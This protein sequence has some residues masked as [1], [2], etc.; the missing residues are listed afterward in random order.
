LSTATRHSHARLYKMTA[1]GFRLWRK[2]I[3]PT[4]KITVLIGLTFLVAI[5]SYQLFYKQA[6]PVH[7]TDI[8]QY[9]MRQLNQITTNLNSKLCDYEN[10]SQ[11]FFTNQ[12][13]NH[14]L[15][16]YIQ[17]NDNYDVATQNMAFANF[18]NGYA[19]TD[20]Y[21]YDAMFLDEANPKRKILTMGES[22][23][24]PFV[25]SFH[26]TKWFQQIVQADG[27][28]MWFPGA[29]LDNTA[30]YYLFLGR[31]VKNLFSNQPLGVLLLVIREKNICAMINDNR[32]GDEPQWEND[33]KSDFTVMTDKRGK[34]MVTPFKKDIG[35]SIRRFLG[36]HRTVPTAIPG[37]PLS[38]SYMSRLKKRPV[39]VVVHP[40]EKTGWHLVNVIPVTPQVNPTLFSKCLRLLGYGIL[41][42]G[43][44]LVVWLGWDLSRVAKT[45]LARKFNRKGASGN[46]LQPAPVWLENLNEKEREVLI[47]V[48]QGYSNK[49]I[50]KQLFMAE[51]TVKNYVSLIYSK[52]EVHD[53]VQASLKAIE[54]GLIAAISKN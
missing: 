2:K 10:M 11:Q 46:K 28:P 48:A 25:R 27:K 24:D 14:L 16:T 32:Y 54:A 43:I 20:P 36:G 9:S 53:R 31:R 52:L 42:S 51:Q 22:L 23:P 3:S 21:F 29:R 17:I 15:T 7:F 1:G 38:H 19:F 26:K 13:L 5:L 18:L 8:S 39:L 30:Q 41:I 35:K 12:D 49:E 40:I 33:L 37:S 4:K 45:W 6:K 44:F 47:L 50:A 34:I